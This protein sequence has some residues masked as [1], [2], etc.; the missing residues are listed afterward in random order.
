MHQE[1]RK[2]RYGLMSRPAGIGCI[3]RDPF[4]LEP[5]LAGAAGQRFT[6]HG[7][8]VFEQPLTE[9]E[10]VAFELVAIAD[11][12]LKRQLVVDVAAKLAPYAAE[13]VQA[14]D[15]DLFE[16]QR[17]VADRIRSAR[18][19][20]VY[21]GETNTFCDQVKLALE[22]VVRMKAGAVSDALLHEDPSVPEANAAARRRHP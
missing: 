12:E 20:R 9:Q 18:P 3:P 8:V 2:H 11:D 6:R 22:D 1:N 19:Y 14:A 16:F 13:Y 10:I 17:T 4:T 7:V 15:A 21:V 5:P